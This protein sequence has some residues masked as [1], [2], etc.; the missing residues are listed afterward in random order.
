M[1]SLAQVRAKQNALPG[2]RRSGTTSPESSG[3]APKE[4]MRVYLLMCNLCRKANEPASS[5]DGCLKSQCPDAKFRGVLCIWRDRMASHLRPSGAGSVHS[6]LQLARVNAKVQL[7]ECEAGELAR[8]IAI[9]IRGQPKSEFQSPLKG[10]QLGH[11]FPIII[12]NLEAVCKLHFHYVKAKGRVRVRSSGERPPG[13]RRSFAVAPN[14]SR[15]Q[16]ETP[17]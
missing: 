12:C 13:W 7:Q 3:S 9:A 15:A 5:H 17:T 8:G 6:I 11:M 1:F 2:H 4:F 10:C 16:S 14:G